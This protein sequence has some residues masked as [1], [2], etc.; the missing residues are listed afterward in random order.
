[1]EQVNKIIN[2]NEYQMLK[3]GCKKSLSMSTRIAGAI[4]IAKVDDGG[5]EALIKKIAL[6]I[7]SNE[8]FPDL[9]E[10]L[11]K[12]ITFKGVSVSFDEHFSK[13]P[14]DL[15]PCVGWSLKENVVPFFDPTA[16]ATLFETALGDLQ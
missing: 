12:N 15:L 16:L 2:G 13:H 6:G 7:I 11:V 10:D 4:D 1:M 8:E 5:T 14:R 3:F 9:V